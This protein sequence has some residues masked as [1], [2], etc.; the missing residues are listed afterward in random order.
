MSSSAP[1]SQPSNSH[2]SSLTA[3]Q[4]EARIVS[5]DNYA[6]RYR[7]QFCTFNEFT[8]LVNSL[9]D[10]IFASVATNM[11]DDRPFFLSRSIY[12]SRSS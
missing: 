10:R 4:K 5:V 6:E 8:S 1:K 11:S 7:E 9:A 3:L 12:S 2:G